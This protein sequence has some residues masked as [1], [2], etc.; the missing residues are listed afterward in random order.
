MKKL[1]MITASSDCA[2]RRSQGAAVT[3]GWSRFALTP[4]VHVPKYP[5]G[6]EVN[7]RAGL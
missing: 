4:N 1:A 5:L 6:S 2:Q 7:D 3:T